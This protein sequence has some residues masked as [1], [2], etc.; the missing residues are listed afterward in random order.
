MN[1]IDIKGVGEKTLSLLHKL[2]I[3]D[4]E[5]LYSYYPYRYEVL[6]RS[7]INTLNQDD[8]V[9]ID[10]YLEENAKIFRYGKKNRMTFRFNTGSNLLNVMIF[11]R[12]FLK[13]KLTIGTNITL[14]GKYDK[15]HNTIIASDIRFSSLGDTTK[16]E[17]IYHETNGLTS[18]K[19]SIQFVIPPVDPKKNL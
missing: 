5:D 15:L 14:I 17:P 6:K 2:N 10:G 19:Y 9:I 16:I 8:K 13:D 7:D 11:N 4:I 1:L 3:Y 12:G 18:K